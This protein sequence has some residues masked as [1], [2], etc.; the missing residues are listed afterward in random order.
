MSD[1]DVHAVYH[2]LF[3]NLSVL[4][5]HLEKEGDDRIIPVYQ[6][7][8]KICEM[9]REDG[10]NAQTES[11]YNHKKWIYVENARLR[12]TALHADSDPEDYTEELLKYCDQKLEAELAELEETWTESQYMAELNQR[13]DNLRHLL[14]PYTTEGDE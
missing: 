3:T 2:E 13:F 8:S 7:I 6:M 11:T 14:E 10:I 4:A 9:S 5:D 12:L 1:I